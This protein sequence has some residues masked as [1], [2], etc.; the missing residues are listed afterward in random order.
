VLL[1]RPDKQE[2]TNHD[3][4]RAGSNQPLLQVANRAVASGTTDFAP[5]GSSTR[6][7]VGIPHYPVFGLV[8]RF[9]RT[10]WGN[11]VRMI[12][13]GFSLATSI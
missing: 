1:Q 12:A 10:L 11:G 7:I 3:L 13:K 9:S 6:L 2:L 5:F 8:F 4:L